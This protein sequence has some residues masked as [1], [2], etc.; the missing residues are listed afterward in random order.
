MIDH[1]KTIEAL[2]LEL[3]RVN[4]LNLEL[5]Q[6]VKDAKGAISTINSSR[7][8]K[9]IIDDA[10]VY[11]QTEEWVRWMLDEVKP[12]LDNIVIKAL[13]TITT[14]EDNDRT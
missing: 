3:D 7:H 12:E 11:W 13:S 5:V 4:A 10:P 1:T 6:A 14:G 9:L 2:T 8:H